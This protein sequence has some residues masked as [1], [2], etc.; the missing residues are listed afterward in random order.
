[1]M[2]DTESCFVP[3]IGAGVSAMPPSN[4]PTWNGFNSL[5]LVSLCE[6]LGRFSDNREPASELLTELESRREET[7]FFGPDFQAQLMEEE[8]GADYFSVWQSLET[9]RYGPVHAQIAEL[10]S[11]GRLPAVITTNF[12][13]LLEKALTARGLPYTVLY[14]ETSFGKFDF[15][16]PRRL[17][18]PIVKIH[19][20]IQNTASLVDTLRQRLAG[21][22]KALQDILDHLLKRFVWVYLG[23]SGRDFDADP[24][25]LNVLSSARDS[26][27]FVFVSRPEDGL[28]IG[29]ERLAAAY[30]SRKSVI[31]IALPD[32]WLSTTFAL[33]QVEVTVGGDGDR[34]LQIVKSRI[35][36]WLA[37]LEPMATINILYSM[38]KSIGLERDASFLMRRTWKSYRSASDIK[39]S[40]YTRYNYNYGSSLLDEGLF[41]NTIPLAED[42]SNIT[43][44]KEAADLNAYE[45]LARSYRHGVLSAAGAR[46]VCI[47]AYRG[48]LAEADSL[49]LK[50]IKR[51]LPTNSRLDLCDIVM[52]SAPLFDILHISQEATA[53][54]EA[55]CEIARQLGDEIRQAELHVLLGRFL[56]YAGSFEAAAAALDEAEKISRRRDLKQTLLS[57][58]AAR[59]LWRAESGDS[60]QSGVRD[61]Q[62]TV[63]E[64]QRFED[65]PWLVKRDLN[66]GTVQ[67]VGGSAPRLCGA[68]LDL[69][70]AA[71]LAEDAQTFEASLAALDSLVADTYIGYR[72]HFYLA[73][74]EGM[75]L[76]GGDR[77]ETRKLIA[78]AREAGQQ[79]GNPWALKMSDRLRQISDS[80]S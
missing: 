59:G 47:L 63:A 78:A 52:Y 38:L 55:C 49:R 70:R 75:L 53:E 76:R 74:A 9:D 77:D 51:A 29:V 37:K 21:R 31:H 24:N 22:P 12:D 42:L 32:V 13:T 46:L 4:L 3:F 26:R 11:R 80:S 50:I 65:V 64:L 48:K 68:W 57:L 67:R 79:Q 7:K 33:P 27:G 73:W 45:F 10:A 40:S 43:E 28:T 60:V 56:T 20:S 16:D 72:P 39:S 41:K 36:D 61:L 62:E 19:G 35:S 58:K 66:S 15:A 23:F 25:Y 54:L 14:D 18:L 5:L 6:S 1:M 69:N 17:A 8:I 34:T 71:M 44:W 2:L 30:G